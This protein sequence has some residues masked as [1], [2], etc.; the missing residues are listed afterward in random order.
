MSESGQLVVV[1][2]GIRAVGQLTLE[3]VAWIEAADVVC[4][5]LADPL[6]ERWILNHAAQAED[7]S[8]LHDPEQPRLYSYAT[9]AAR[10]VDHARR[11]RTVV[12]VFYGHPGVFTSPSHWALELAASEGIEARMLPGVSAEDCLFA[13]LGVDPGQG[14]FQ[15]YEA[16]E[17]LLTARIPSPDAHVV[18]W[19]IGVVAAQTLATGSGLRVFVDYLLRFYPAN[20]PV[21]HYRAPQTVLGR[22]LNQPVPLQDLADVP[23]SVTSTLYIPPM[24]KRAIDPAVV[25]ELDDGSSPQVEKPP[26]HFGDVRSFVGAH[27]DA[28]MALPE[29]DWYTPLPAEESRLEALIHAIDDPETLSK[30]A[31]AP[32]VFLGAAGLDTIEMW[33]ALAGDEDWIAACVRHGSGAAAAVALGLAESEQ[34][35]RTFQIGRDGRLLRPRR[36]T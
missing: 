7:L 14:A 3:T 19:Q 36:T 20:H 34:Q 30:Y 6:T 12:G 2:S 28:T 26:T 10:L 33:S 9:M 15:A 35:A 1:G 22:A 27:G 32:G 29:P 17:M 5:V 11:G 18:V 16:T 21:T 4:Y 25:A 23:V 13:D 8:R 24:V 31:A